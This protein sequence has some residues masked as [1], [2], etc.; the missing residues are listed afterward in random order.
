M[1]RYAPD[2]TVYIKKGEQLHKEVL[3]LGHAATS[4]YIAMCNC[5]IKTMVI[6]F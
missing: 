2:F 6:V 1:G 4:L 5:K 3:S